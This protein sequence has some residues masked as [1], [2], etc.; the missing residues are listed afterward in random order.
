[1]VSV[2]I[3]DGNYYNAITMNRLDQLNLGHAQLIRHLCGSGVLRSPSLINA[4]IKADRLKFVTSTYYDSAYL[5]EAL[6]IGYGATIS[7]PTTVAFMLE[8]L[9]CQPGQKVLDIGTGSG[10]KTAL[11]A[12][13][14]ESAGQIFTI[15]RVPELV[16]QAK[17][18]LSS[19]AY[20]NIN[21]IVGD[22]SKGLSSQA[23][24]DRIVVSAAAK[25]FPEVLKNQLTVGGRLVLPVGEGVQDIVAV[26]RLSE[27]EWDEEK[28]P[29]FVFVPLIED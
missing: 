20:Q 2:G 21:F 3:G 5:D 13:L 6:P 1:M 24:F 29:G 18:N 12:E 16:E 19:F 27:D 23:P 14:V 17:K 7:Q 22:G 11:L 25:S 4:F 8:L 9:Q 28:Y 10:W 15:E 26:T